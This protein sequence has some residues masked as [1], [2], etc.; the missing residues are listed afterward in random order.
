MEIDGDTVSKSSAHEVGVG[1]GLGTYSE[2]GTPEGGL[3]G[4]VATGSKS[5]DREGTPCQPPPSA[6]ATLVPKKTVPTVPSGL[7]AADPCSTFLIHLR[8]Q[9]LN[10][11][12]PCWGTI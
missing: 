7:E 8:N 5:A 11:H 1:R 12:Q 6:G 9:D 10:K 3:R 2:L 4:E